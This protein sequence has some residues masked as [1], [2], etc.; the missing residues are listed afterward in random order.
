MEPRTACGF[1]PR[2]Q[3]LNDQRSRAS[4]TSL[5]WVRRHLYKKNYVLLQTS[6]PYILC[7]K[8]IPIIRKEVVS[9]SAHE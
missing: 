3:C 1:N 4:R 2:F 5:S 6:R 7:F 8:I 9:E